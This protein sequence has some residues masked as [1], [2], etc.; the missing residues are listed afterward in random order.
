ME[1][2]ELIPL[3]ALQ[4][5]LYCPRQ[6]ALIHLEQQWAENRYTS[7]GRLQ[8]QHADQART[9][10]RGGIRIA[11]A[12]PLAA[13]EL[14]V[15]GVADIV[16][17]HA[18]P[19]GETIFPVEYKRGKPKKHHADEVQL[20]AQA[21]C[22]ED[23]FG[24]DIVEG[25]LYYGKNRRRQWVTF[26]DRLRHLTL[27]SIAA[28]RALFDNGITPTASY[29]PERCDNCSLIDLCQPKLLAKGKNITRWL[30]QQWED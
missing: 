30:Q 19:G 6:C 20:C 7:E 15:G 24:Q 16:E 11:C 10:S 13:P 26:D 17:F 21:M 27:D 28:T 14:G 9:E 23:M 22:L 25:A 8:H 12:M 1:H 4:H 5:Y 2:D 3:S 18:T 29:Q